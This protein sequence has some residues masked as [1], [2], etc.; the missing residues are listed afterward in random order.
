MYS[1]AAWRGRVGALT[2]AARHAD[3][4]RIHL[5]CF[6]D[7]QPGTQGPR[8]VSEADLRAAFSGW[9]VDA[10]RS[11]LEVIR[12]AAEAWLATITRPLPEA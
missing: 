4:G 2:L 3:G 7:L 5:L 10:E 6:S 12:G 8:R 9:H 1:R 11:R